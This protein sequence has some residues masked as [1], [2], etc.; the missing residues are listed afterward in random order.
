MEVRIGQLARATGTTAPTI[1]YY[2][3][4]GLLPSPLRTG[5]QRRYSQD[6]VRRL[7]FIRR[8][9]DF[10]FP[11]D[12]V[13]KLTMLMHDRERSCVEARTLAEAHLAAV[14]E[15]VRELCTLEQEIA[16]YLDAADGVCRGG[17]GADCV[18]LD[19]LASSITP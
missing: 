11:I 12:Q 17:P 9:R 6:D 4:I 3:N 16:G 14:R 1:R 19:R 18:I 10:G 13:R 5:G 8:C 2:E 7:T 15:K